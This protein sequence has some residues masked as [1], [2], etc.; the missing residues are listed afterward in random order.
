MTS[1]PDLETVG[2]LLF[3]RPIRLRLAIW[4]YTERGS[5][6]FWLSEA[7]V[8]LNYSA[9]AVS[10]ELARLT[11]LGMVTRIDVGPSSRRVYFQLVEENPLWEA[12]SKIAAMYSAAPEPSNSPKSA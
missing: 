11:R 5:Q 6:P 4:I 12:I 8:A 1:I 10:E 9:S 3:G 2:K 7:S